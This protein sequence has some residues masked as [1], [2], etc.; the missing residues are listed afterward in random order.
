MTA[1]G[2]VVLSAAEIIALWFSARAVNPDIPLTGMI[3]S[4][5]LNMRTGQVNY[6]TFDTL[7]RR[8]CICEFVR[9]WTGVAISPGIGEYTPAR[10]PG[11]YTTLEK[12]YV[13]MTIA[14][15]TG[16]HPEMGIGH[17][18]AGLTLS[19]VQLLLDR[20]FTE[21]L[22]H[23]EPPVVDKDTIGLDTILDIGFGIERNYLDTE[24]T[25]KNFRS[26][27][28]EPKFFDTSGWDGESEAGQLKKAADRIKSLLEEY[29]KPEVD[30]GKLAKVRQV[31]D[32]AKKEMRIYSYNNHEG[33]GV[34]QT[35]ERLRF[36]AKHL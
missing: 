8:L 5:V 17:L 23:L 36:A 32:K 30:P 7:I 2:S 3:L 10:R 29:K 34:Y 22:K 19:P 9:G 12:A 21:G 31:V 24:H 28:W 15:F 6:W 27:L 35:L 20:E 33:G 14:A 4:G 18:E 25:V 1:A 26:C 16:H 13:A 11:F